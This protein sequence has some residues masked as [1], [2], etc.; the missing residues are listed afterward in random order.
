[1]YKYLYV[2]Q[3]MNN[4]TYYYRLLNHYNFDYYVGYIN[5]YNHKLLIIDKIIIESRR[6]DFAYLKKRT[7]R[8][9]INFLEKI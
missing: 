9:I 3:N 4:N 2:W 8:N 7:I 5:Q 1:M 6:K